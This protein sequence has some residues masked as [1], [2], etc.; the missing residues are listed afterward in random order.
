MTEEE[1]LD[2]VNA[3]IDA[4]KIF[5]QENVSSLEALNLANNTFHKE[6]LGL[7]DQSKIL[8]CDDDRGLPLMFGWIATEDHFTGEL[9]QDYYL[10]HIIEVTYGD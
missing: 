6:E 7:I 10:D 9:D 8:E 1:Y 2:T 4:Q 5:L 3:Y